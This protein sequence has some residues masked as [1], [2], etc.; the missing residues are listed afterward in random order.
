MNSDKKTSKKS[1]PKSVGDMLKTAREAVGQDVAFVSNALRIREDHLVALE[2]NDI[3]ALP[4]QAYAIG[5]IRTYATYLELDCDS[6]I[7]LYKDQAGRASGVRLDFPVMKDKSELPSTALVIGLLV[8]VAAA[9]LFW[10]FLMTAEEEMIEK[11]AP[12]NNASVQ[13]ETPKPTTQNVTP[14]HIPTEEAGEAAPVQAERL[15]NFAIVARGET[16]MRVENDKGRILF[17]SIVL[18]G[19]RFE[20]PEGDSFRLATRNAG[21]LDYVHGDKV[22]APV[23]ASGQILTRHRINVPR[24]ISGFNN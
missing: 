3:Q 20:F 6:L 21:L 16:W 5:F 12:Q 22:I 14:A 7:E 18:A 23:G 17:S 9:Y 4:A 2:E 10:A 11:A 1:S 13:V 15:S 19:E 8:V 24:L